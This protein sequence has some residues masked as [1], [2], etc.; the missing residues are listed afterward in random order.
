MVEL[1]QTAEGGLDIVVDKF[2]V[3]VNLLA[4]G[5]GIAVVA[6]VVVAGARLGWALMPWILGIGLV[7]WLF[8]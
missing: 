5:F 7:A 6:A 8:I 3:F 1:Q 2:D 4:L